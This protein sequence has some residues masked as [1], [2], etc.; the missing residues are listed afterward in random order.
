MISGITTG[1]KVAF[2][3]IS[4]FSVHIILGRKIVKKILVAI[5]ILVLA[6]AMFAGCNISAID[7]GNNFDM[8]DDSGATNSAGDSE[9]SDTTEKDDDDGN[10]DDMNNTDKPTRKPITNGGGFNFDDVD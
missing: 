6:F 10:K 9:N 5:L 1:N 8:T 3:G 4:I 7:T 2:Y